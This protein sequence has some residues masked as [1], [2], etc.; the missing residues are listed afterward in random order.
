MSP[1]ARVLTLSVAVAL[2]ACVAPEDFSPINLDRIHRDRASS[3][4]AE[5]RWDEAY[6]YMKKVVAKDDRSPFPICPA[7]DYLELG[8]YAGMSCR[9]DEAEQEMERAHECY[10]HG[11]GG[12]EYLASLELAELQFGRK[13]YAA[14][15]V[16]FK[17]TFEEMD[18]R[19]P[20]S[21][22]IA[23]RLDDYAVALEESGDHAGAVAAHERVYAWRSEH[24][25]SRASSTP[26]PYGSNCPESA[27]KD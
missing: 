16:Q 14:A 8:V 18:D 26:L 12:L 4:A 7:R 20:M 11:K 5:K 15:A 25:G 6:A 13:K 2:G 19:E 27:A 24:R 10:L 17:Q 23:L 1:I 21:E 9:F 3:A 22:T